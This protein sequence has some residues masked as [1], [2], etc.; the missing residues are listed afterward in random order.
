MKEKVTKAVKISLSNFNMKIFNIIIL[1]CFFTC[2][3]SSFAEEVKIEADSAKYNEITGEFSVFG[4][5]KV[6]YEQERITADSA[7][8]NKF[9][10]KLIAQGNVKY[11]DKNGNVFTT[12]EIE[13]SNKFNLAKATNIKIVLKNESFIFADN[14]VKDNGIETLNNASYT[15]C[16]VTCKDSEP[17]WKIKATEVI[18]NREK[19][20]IYYKNALFKVKNIPVFYTPIFTSYI[21]QKRTSGILTP[22]LIKNTFLGTAFKLPIYFNLAPNQDLVIAPIYSQ[23][24]NIIF[25]MDYRYLNT[26]GNLESNFS[27]KKNEPNDNIDGLKNKN[28]R[29]HL[30]LKAKANIKNW[31]N[32]FNLNLVTD[33]NYL[34]N[35]E[36]LK[37]KY[38]INDTNI[39]TSKIDIQKR[40]N[41]NKYTFKALYFQNLAN[42]RNFENTTTVLPAINLKTVQIQNNGSKIKQELDF[43]SIYKRNDK[44]INRMSLDFRYIYPYITNNGIL[45]SSDF[46]IH[47]DIYSYKRKKSL[48]EQNF[49]D[50]SRIFPE[51]KFEAQ[52]PLISTFQK[53]SFIIVPIANIAFK[54]QVNYNKNVFFED[55]QFNEIDFN[56]VFVSN[57]YS[58]FD[59]VESGTRYNYGLRFNFKKQNTRDINFLIG[60]SYYQKIESNEQLGKKKY[61]NLI[62]K[63]G[64]VEGNSLFVNYAFIL[65]NKKYSILKHTISVGK[66]YQK[67]SVNADYTAVYDNIP[68]AN[69]VANKKELSLSSKAT[70]YKNLD[71]NFF[72]RYDLTS[73]KY[74]KSVNSNSTNKLTKLGGSVTIHHNCAKLD[75]TAEQDYT[76][77]KSK[78]N[79]TYWI[80]IWLKNLV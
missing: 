20:T 35:Y 4:D 18:I 6:N 29:G 60:Q 67:Y 69:N 2:V 37:K 61:S 9:L 53:N 21:K 49:K 73:K 10:D 63:I 58:G 70:L 74:N 28:F 48:I 33:K 32:D 45:T 22:S 30:F 68:D 75:L 13:L 78:P 3:N 25:E 55:S 71:I 7:I 65:S 46:I 54:P 59:T 17:L 62:G 1:C 44:N 23:K 57:K 16:Q 11:Y 56:N 43:A 51:V 77:I 80:K 26:F 24:K 19:N 5:I 50:N 15:S 8:Y 14:V 39:L 31:Y 72:L 64:L 76:R 38:S 66:N 47:S 52:Y 27:Y 79:N 34:R 41:L 42:N 12:E 40:Y 36:F